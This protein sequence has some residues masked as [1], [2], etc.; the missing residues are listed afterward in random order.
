VKIIIE[1]L[2][3]RGLGISQIEDQPIEVPFALPGE[4]ASVEVIHPKRKTAWG[5][6]L[7]L[8]NPSPLRGQPLCKH[9]G[10]CGGCL[11]QHLTPESY[12]GFKITRI[13]DLLNA[14][15]VVP[16]SWGE[17]YFIPPGK[18]RRIDMAGRMN[19]GVLTF[20]FHNINS[21]R[22]FRIE[23]CAVVHP[24]ITALFTPLRSCLEG[25][26]TEGEKVHVFFTL[27]SNG[28]DVLVAG[29]GR[30]LS[31]VEESALTAFAQT[32]DLVRL[33]Y[34]FQGK[35]VLHQRALPVITFGETSVEVAS[36]AFLQSSFEAD[37]ILSRL[38]QDNIPAGTTRVADL[39]CGR[40]TLSLPLVARG[41]TV[42]G[43]ESDVH[44]MK[45][46]GAVKPDRMTLHIRNLFESPL[47][48]DELE[49]YDVV[50]LNPPRAGI[51]DQVST[52][53]HS[54][55]KRIIYV[56]CGP[57]SFARDSA[58]LVAG[59]Y[60]LSSLTLVDQFVF[61]PHT[62]IVGVFDLI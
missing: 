40:G 33:I 30:D 19:E 53:A 47:T 27:A 12:R 5:R 49:N 3:D 54:S 57:E 11:L 39:F 55:V 23:E 24:Q 16:Q 1:K 13:K 36:N 56:S 52:L 22:T 6:L 60:T 42:E 58:A 51:K 21:K 59:G 31:P 32:H 26:M 18:R 4:E 14:H 41:F 61:T 48:A 44:A 62:E 34:K 43:Y 10:E 7:S 15:G 29:I 9:F 17:P 37:Q 28:V 45:A 35:D 20:G 8:S 25:I 38:V 50:I 2:N 46:L